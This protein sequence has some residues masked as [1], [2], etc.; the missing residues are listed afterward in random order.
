MLHALVSLLSYCMR[1]FL[2]EA[3]TEFEQTIA[4]LKSGDAK[5]ALSE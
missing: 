4:E 3:K 5:A 2:L 1:L